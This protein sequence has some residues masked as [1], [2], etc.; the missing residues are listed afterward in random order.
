MPHLIP[1]LSE[2]A[3]EILN[4]I[5][6]RSIEFGPNQLTPEIIVVSAIFEKGNSYEIVKEL[7]RID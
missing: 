2:K 3:Q 6:E 4:L 7:G 1:E 5:I